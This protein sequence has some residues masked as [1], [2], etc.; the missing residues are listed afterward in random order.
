MR[1]SGSAQVVRQWY[2]LVSQLST[3]SLTQPWSGTSQFS[4]TYDS[5]NGVHK[6]MYDPLPK[7]S[8]TNVQCS[9]N[10]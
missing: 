4:L 10:M 1:L 2:E 6:N 5:V 8:T 3:S 9:I 7:K